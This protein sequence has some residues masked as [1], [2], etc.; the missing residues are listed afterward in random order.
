MKGPHLEVL[1]E[2]SWTWNS[3]LSVNTH[4]GR[5]GERVPGRAMLKCREVSV[6]CPD[7]EGHGHDS[8]PYWRLRGDKGVSHSGREMEEA[9]LEL[10]VGA[11][12]V[13]S[14]TP[15]GLFKVQW[16]VTLFRQLTAC[17]HWT[18]A[19]NST[20]H[21]MQHFRSFVYPLFALPL[22]WTKASQSWFWRWNSMLIAW[23]Y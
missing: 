22:R 19:V 18:Q 2:T 6:V 7:R 12:L 15:V 10:G 20:W 4:R 23:N 21:S 16:T 5:G 1:M 8:T 14:F 9:S 13:L 11:G 17:S 3:T